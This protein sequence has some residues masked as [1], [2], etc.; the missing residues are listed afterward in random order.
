MVEAFAG[1]G[2]GLVGMA[3]E[4]RVFGHRVAMQ[5]DHL[6]VGAIE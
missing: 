1:A 2:A 6:H 3:E 4:E 5:V